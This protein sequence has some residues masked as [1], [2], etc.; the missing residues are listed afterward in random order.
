MEVQDQVMLRASKNSIT[1]L[2]KKN[3]VLGEK[4]NDFECL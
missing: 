4:W 1:Q 3:K 2:E